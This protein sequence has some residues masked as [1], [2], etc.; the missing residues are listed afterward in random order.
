MFTMA[1][2]RGVL[3]LDPLPARAYAGGVDWDW[4]IKSNYS[5]LGYAAA[6]RLAGSPKAIQDVQESSRHYFQRPD[7]TAFHLDPARDELAGWSSRVGVSK[8]G[9]RHL[10]FNT[11]VGVMSPGYDVNDVGFLRRA[12][13]RWISNWVQV[14]SETPNRWSRSRTL[15]LNQWAGWNADGDRILG[16]HNA[17]GIVQFNNNATLGVGV[18]RDWTTLDDRLTRGG[19]VGRVDGSSVYFSFFDSDKRRQVFLNMFNGGGRD[20]LGSWF[21]DHE[22][23][24]TYRPVPAL[25]IAPGLRINLATRDAQWVKNVTDA[26]THYVF[27]HLEQTTVAVTSRINYTITATL[28]LES[29]AQPF[30]SGGFYNAFKELVDGRNPSYADRYTPYQLA[31]VGDDNPDFNV[32]SFRTTQRHALGVQAR[33]N[34]V[35]GLATGTGSDNAYRRFP[36]APQ[37]RRCI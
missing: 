14:R 27:G 12:D 34:A 33:V 36:G 31:H 21:R 9:G 32:R 8:I 19:P 22:F 10:K 6:S 25:S 2:R 11:N 4:R 5:V 20:G 17:I 23:N 35:R 13:Q 16:G 1:D 3:V 7:A 18:G 24:V 28:S 29:Y 15:N 37:P 26:G 30:V